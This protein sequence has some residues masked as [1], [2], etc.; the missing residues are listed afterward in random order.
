MVVFVVN[1]L[2]WKIMVKIG[3]VIMLSFIVVGM[4]NKYIMWNV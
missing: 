2:C 4:F 1:V 3:F